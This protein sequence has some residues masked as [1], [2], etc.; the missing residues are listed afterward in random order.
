LS[1]VVCPVGAEEAADHGDDATGFFRGGGS[2]A[3]V[4]G[5]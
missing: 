2:V 5:T 4:F 1:C 3:P